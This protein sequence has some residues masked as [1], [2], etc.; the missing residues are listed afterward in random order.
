MSCWYVIISAHFP[1]Q[2]SSDWSISS[3]LLNLN[4]RDVNKADHWHKIWGTQ[5]RRPWII[6]RQQ[7][8]SLTTWR[9]FFIKISLWCQSSSG[10]MRH[11][12]FPQHVWET[13]EREHLAWGQLKAGLNGPSGETKVTQ[14]TKSRRKER[15]N[16]F[17][18]NYSRS[19]CL[20]APMGEGRSLIFIQIHLRMHFR[21]IQGAQ[22][23]NFGI[24]TILLGINHE[25]V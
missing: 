17:P 3:L 20:A 21:V 23:L 16:I 4:L 11:E 25:T 15:G 10:T 6:S 1:T 2:K 7:M 22:H 8:G 12:H 19:Y 24:E 9:W 5:W 13:G 14:G 18:G